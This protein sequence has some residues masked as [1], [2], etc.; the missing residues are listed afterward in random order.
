MYCTETPQPTNTMP[1]KSVSTLML[2]IELLKR[3]PRTGAVSPQDLHRAL[4]GS[5]HERDERTIQRHLKTLVDAN[6]IDCDDSSK[7]HS[8]R[9]KSHADG[10]ALSNLSES[11]ALLLALAQQ[12]L[13]HLLPAQL[14]QQMSGFFDQAQSQLR[15]HSALTTRTWLNKTRFV[16]TLQPLLAPPI[17]DGVFEAVSNALFG[18]HW[19]RIAYTNANQI[20]KTADIMPLGLVQV[21]N[22][23]LYLVCQFE[24]YDDL[25]Q[26][27]L[28]RFESAQIRERTFTPPADFN[29][30]AYDANGAF[31]YGTGER[32]RLTLDITH[33]AGL[34]LLE[35]RL[36]NDQTVETFNDFYRIRATVVNSTQLDK[37]ILSHGSN[38][39]ASTIEPIQ[40]LNE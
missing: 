27:A 2:T 3:I 6:Y 11:E 40:P 35:S 29:L 18:N 38:A 31:G 13:T 37:F 22:G 4:I 23:R 7:P 12:H 16:S 21:D 26:L 30:A 32:V 1:K 34:Y 5:P 39:I 9:W 36:S 25:R 33:H 14:T 20:L 19:L 28:N 8:Y 15:H 10:L 24:G 17:A